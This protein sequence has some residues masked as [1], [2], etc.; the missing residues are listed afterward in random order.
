MKNLAFA[1]LLLLASLASCSDKEATPPA[2]Q[3]V[4]TIP[5]LVTQIRK[6]AKLYSAE[7]QLHKIVTHEDQM[8]LR[9]SFMAKEFNITL[10]LGD[11]KIAI[12]ID[13]TLKAYVDFAEFNEKNVRRRGQKIEITLPDPKVELTSSKI[14]HA[15]IKKQ[16]SLLRNNFSDAEMANYEK[17]GRAAILNDVPKLG[18]IEM[19]RENAA[20]T[21]IPMLI[22]MGFQESDITITFRK[23]F[24]NGDL[25]KLLDTKSLAR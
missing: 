10:P 7:Y 20:N 16:V 2:P 19:A 1:L 17:Q 4:D 18:I 12:P 8:K 15:E 6:C 11:R 3:E 9:G 21:L 24:S 13:A 23:Q 22:S 25:P 5:M 14:N